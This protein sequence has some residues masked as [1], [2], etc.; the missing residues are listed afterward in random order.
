MTLYHQTYKLEMYK[1]DEPNFA[2]SIFSHTKVSNVCNNIDLDKKSLELVIQGMFIIL[3]N[4]YR[5][6]NMIVSHSVSETLTY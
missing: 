2:A 4:S 1:Y 6:A 3:T 5:V